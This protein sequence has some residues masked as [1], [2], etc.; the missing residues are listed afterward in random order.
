MLCKHWSLAD[1]D[2]KDRIYFDIFPSKCKILPEVNTSIIT[3][4]ISYILEYYKDDSMSNLELQAVLYKVIN[5]HLT[6]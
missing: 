2:N 6:C 3:L 1:E 4:L 5:I